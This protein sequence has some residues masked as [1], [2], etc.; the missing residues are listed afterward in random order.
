LI[1]AD[2]RRAWSRLRRRVEAVDR[3]ADQYLDGSDAKWP[4]YLD[5]G[6][7]RSDF[8]VDKGQKSD[9]YDCEVLTVME[10][11]IAELRRG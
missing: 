8:A 10:R 3:R 9:G 5:L 7:E 2:V 1:F 4:Q 6:R 11:D